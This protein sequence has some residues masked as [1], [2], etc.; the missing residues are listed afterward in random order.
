VS[1]DP[2]RHAEQVAEVAGIL[3][4]AFGADGM[5]SI[6]VGGSAIVLHAPGVHVTGDI[7]LIIERGRVDAT[8][9]ER[10]FSSLGFRREGR[11]W[12]IN[13]LFVEVPSLSLSDPSERMRVGEWVFEVVT[14]EVVLADR[15]VGFRQWGVIAYG[16]QAIDMIAAFGVTIDED[17][18]QAKLRGEGSLDALDPLRSLARRDDPVTDELLRALLDHLR[19]GERWP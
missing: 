18:L 10:V 8:A 7:D 3:H 13:N 19:S 11:H 4:E 15:I 9:I 16:Q 17:W 12:R 6:V 5:R 1:A 14:K 2:L